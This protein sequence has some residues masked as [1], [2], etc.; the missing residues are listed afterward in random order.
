MA[1]GFEPYHVP[2]QSRR[3]KLRVLLD[4]TNNNSLQVPLYDD[5]SSIVVLPTSDLSIFQEINGNPFLYTP[6]IP[7]F[8]DQ[9]FHHHH[10][11]N[12]NSNT[13][14]QGNLS[15]SL[16]S[17]HHTTSSS[18][19][20][21]LSSKSTTATTCVPLGPFTGYSLILKRSRFLKPAQILLDELCDV[22]KGIYAADDYS[23]LMMDP[24]QSYSNGDELFGKKK[25]RLISMLDEVYQK[26]KQY[27]EQLQMVVA[28][29]ESVA[30][31]GN[32]APFANIAI[33]I[34]TKHFKCLKDA[35]TDQLLQF[36]T[37]SNK[38]S[39]HHHHHHGQINCERSSSVGLYCQRPE[40]TQPIWRPQRGLP[41]RSVTVLRAWLFEHFL[42]PYPTDTDKVMLAKQTG[43]SRN[44]VS[45]WFINARVRIW[46]P[47]V[48]EIHMLETREAHNKSSEIREGQ[49]NSSNN[50]N[51]PI[52]HFPMSNSHA[53]ESS[54][55]ST[56]APRLQDVPSKRTRNDL[57]N[58]PSNIGSVADSIN[59]SYGNLSTGAAGG[60]SLTL[61]LHQ[62]SGN[63]GLSEPFPI[64]NAARRF[65]IENN[66]NSGRFMVGGFDE[67][68]GQFG[69]NSMIGGQYLHDFAG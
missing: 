66:T 46:K 57:V 13:N 14:G 15:L 1:E 61:G 33:K 28:S 67:Q 50:N 22:G 17:L 36:T 12:S 49:N 2:Q 60:V 41:E 20:N 16:S 4:D 55:P 24:P 26:Y 62:N 58:I 25:S 32:A 51:N 40:S 37:T 63:I 45:N 38:S 5:P 43:L 42:H 3:D 47:M 31:L 39:S 11:H 65:G 18:T 68:S 64:I 23:T 56:S 69:R 30:G 59:L 21:D 48:E 34:M 53:C 8:L 44:Q 19:N 52:E 7:R 54:T 27:H 9:S 6:Q 10:H 29:F 35:I